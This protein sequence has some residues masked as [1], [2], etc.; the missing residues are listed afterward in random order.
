MAANTKLSRSA[1]FPLR[2]SNIGRAF[3]VLIPLLSSLGAQ[4]PTVAMKVDLVAWGDTITGLSLKSG[5]KQA[6]VSAL[7][8]RYSDPVSYSGPVILEIRKAGSSISSSSE[9]EISEEDKQHEMKPLTAPDAKTDNDTPAK[10][11][12]GITLELENRRKKDPSIVALAAL[13]KSGC[14]RATVLLA[15]ADGGTFTAYVIDDDPS[16]LPMGQL[17]IH[18]LSPI[19]IAMRCN[20]KQ[21]AELKTSETLLVPAHNEQLIYE[22]AYKLGDKWKMQENNIIQLRSTEQVQMMVLKSDN[23]FFQSTDGSSGGFL[24]IVTLRR[25]SEG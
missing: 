18:N 21:G 16:K 22:L 12:Q 19:P 6:V 5:E 3:L 23:S 17:R 15:P 10:P 20:G 24:Q 2:K 25:G 8:F 13:P 1:G 7:G 11:K 9:Q 4:E 14:R